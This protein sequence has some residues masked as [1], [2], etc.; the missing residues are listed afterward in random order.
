MG[1][2]LYNVRN[3]ATELDDISRWQSM[4]ENLNMMPWGIVIAIA[5]ALIVVAVWRHKSGG[6]RQAVQYLAV[7]ALPL[8]WYLFA[9]NHSYL[10]CWF[11]YRAQAASVAALL[12]AASAMVDWERLITPNIKN[13]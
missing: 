10:H 11:T 3:R 2:G 8:A 6:W 9:A 12:M 13:D 4:V 5:L 1:N 7:A